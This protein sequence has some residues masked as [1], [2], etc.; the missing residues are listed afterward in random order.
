[1]ADPRTQRLFPGRAVSS[2]A[3]VAEVTARQDRTHRPRAAAD[4]LLT[5]AV[6]AVVPVASLLAQQ[7]T[8]QPATPPPAA[9]ANAQDPQ[10]NVPLMKTEGD[11]IA[12]SFNETNGMELPEFI[13]WT[14]RMTGKVFTFNDTELQAAGQGTRITFV[15]TLRI[16]KERFREDFFA[17]F[18]TMLYIKGFA[19]V[20]RGKG[21]LEML[22]IVSMNGP[23]NKEITNG[24]IYVTLEDIDKYASQTG[25]PILTTVPLTNINATVASN[26]LRPFFAAAGPAQAQ[27]QIGNVGNNTAMLL[28]GF[29]PQVYAAV[30]LL[31]LVDVPTELP[32]LQIQ[33]VRLEHAA[34]EEIEPLLNDIL[35]DRNRIRAA[36]ATEGG[37]G[38]TGANIQGGGNSQLKVAVHTALKAIILSGTVEQI[39]DAQ[40][41]IA[42]LD[43]PPEPF[44]GQASVVRLQNVL[45]DELRTTLNQFVQE[46]QQAEQ[47]AGATGGAAG[48]A[49]AR[50]PRRTV[51]QAH[52]ESDSLIISATATKYKQ[53][54]GLVEEL[55]RR[56]PQV[57]I[58][59]ALV[60]LQT[61]DLTN[62]GVELGLID[63][64]EGDSDY[65]RGF[66]FTSFGLS[67]FED[68]DDDGYP[69][70]RL[71]N[72]DAPAQGVTGGIIRGDGF[73]LP[74]LVN[75]LQ[76]DNRAN[77]LSTP[78]VLVNN[79]EQATV[80]TTEERPTTQVSQGNATTSTGV[81]QPR[82]AGITLEISPTI[83]PNNYLRLSITLT[84][85]RFVGQFDPSS[86]TGGGVVLGRSISTRVTMPSDDTMVLGGVIE[87]QEAYSE[88]GIPLLKDIPLLGALFRQSSSTNNKTNLYFFL[89][90]TILDEPDFR[91]L[92][93]VSLQRKMQ[94]ETYIG[95]RRLQIVDRRWT[96]GAGRP[97]APQTL[98]EGSIEEL[99]ANGGNETPYLPP[100]R[101]DQGLR[102]PT[103]PA[104]PESG[105]TK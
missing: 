90:P 5:L 9:T 53:I 3:P 99:D 105:T 66:G 103:G 12:F 21:D 18:Q 75:A 104:S 37:Q 41:L 34:A 61:G 98:E 42:K 83:S 77:I 102:S 54:L 36:A 15:G 96:G 80:E 44:D 89:T 79:N 4:R 85:S 19:I 92:K 31:Q 11:Y 40:E 74:I 38:P 94:A 91:D 82:D 62:L 14:E 73:A 16:K 93:Q 25:V 67:S 1:M 17:F 10:G 24:A 88:S 23:R 72:F 101:R 46:D 100:V 59:A 56:Q 78:S 30:K 97:S 76:Q 57:L 70:T 28:Q 47:Q 71:P 27:L 13:K 60:E 65:T 26:A 8:P 43:V 49:A 29:G 95:T 69:D 20:P 63:V 86:P 7:P 39:R 64:P 50:R 6:A 84:V 22:E 45:A 68:T 55:D 48:A 81:G 32:D 58:E 2:P 33:V 51:I 52:K 87:D 35:N